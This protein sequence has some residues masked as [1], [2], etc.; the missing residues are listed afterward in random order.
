MYSKSSNSTHLCPKNT[1]CYSK[2]CYICE[3]KH[4]AIA[5]N[6]TNFTIKSN[7]LDQKVNHFIVKSH[8]MSSHY[9]RTHCTAKSMEIFLIISQNQAGS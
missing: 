6:R 5:S 1:S 8:Y 4:H 2:P 3:P 7:I 9:L